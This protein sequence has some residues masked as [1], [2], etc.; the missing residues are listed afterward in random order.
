MTELKALVMLADCKFVCNIRYAFQDASQLY[1]VLDLAPGGD[2][3]YN[4]RATPNARFTE[5]A[6]K[7]F[8]AQI[9]L[10]LDYCHRSSILHRGL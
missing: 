8:I 4:L 7:I 6:A 10:A 2:M 5:A 9:F 3:R 1:M